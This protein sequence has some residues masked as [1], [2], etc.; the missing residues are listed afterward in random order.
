MGI[1]WFDIKGKGGFGWIVRDHEGHA[2]FGGCKFISKGSSVS[3]LEAEAILARL[4]LLVEECSDPIPPLTV[5]SDALEVIRLLNWD[6]VSYA[7]IGVI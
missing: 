4:N 2:V 6:L 7:E 5:E 3:R 1:A